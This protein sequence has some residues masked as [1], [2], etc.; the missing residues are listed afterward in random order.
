M[1]DL[2][3]SVTYLYT[4]TGTG[5]YNEAL[6]P[7]TI[8][9][10]WMLA[11]NEVIGDDQARR[12]RRLDLRLLRRLG[13][14]LHVLRRP[15]AQRASAGSTRSRATAPTTTWSG[16]RPR[17]TSREWFRPNPPLPT[18][19]LGPA[20][21]HQHPAVGVLFSLNHVAKNRETYLENYWLK[22]KRSV[23]KG[24]N[25]PTVRVGDPG[26]PAAEGRCRRRGQRA[27]H[28]RASRSTSPTADFKA[29]K[30]SVK[31][32]RLLI[33]A[34]Q[35]YRTLADMYFSVQNYP[36]ANPRP[37]DDTG[38]TF[39]YMRNIVAPARHRRRL[40]RPADDAAHRRRAGRRR[41]RGDAARSSWSTTPPTTT[42]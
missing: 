26:R 25:G 27:P 6:D 30:V 35:P 40:P 10:W 34:D 12:A 21:Q 19:Q 14:E 13:P 41:H 32:G 24:K 37:Y 20:Q 18:H 42:S 4:S 15:R 33:R 11:K 36:P 1:H 7:I 28:A 23:E 8:D 22:N 16:R 9:E 17:T 31:A 39:Q 29:G 5:P 2:H 38:W 3:E